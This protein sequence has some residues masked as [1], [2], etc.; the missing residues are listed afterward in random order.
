MA[1]GDNDSQK[2][3][4]V[5]LVNTKSGERLA[6]GYLITNLKTV[7]GNSNVLDLMDYVRVKIDPTDGNLKP[8]TEFADD[9]QWSDAAPNPAL[10]EL[11]DRLK[12][13]DGGGKLIIAGGDGTV[14]WGIQLIEAYIAKFDGKVKS[15][16]IAIIPMGTGNDLSRSL[17]MGPGFR[18]STTCCCGQ[19]DVEAL[20][21]SFDSAYEGILDLWDVT[22]SSGGNVF[23]KRMLINYISVGM[24][25]EIAHK[26]DTFRTNHPTLCKSRKLNKFWYAM[27]GFRSLCGQAT[28]NTIKKMKLSGSKQSAS[29]LGVPELKSLIVANIDSYASGMDFWKQGGRLGHTKFDDGELEICGYYGGFHMGCNQVGFRKSKRLAKASSVEF[30]IAGHTMVQIDGEPISIPGGGCTVEIK[31]HPK[32]ARVLTTV[33]KHATKDLTV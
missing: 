19:T 6:A 5:A 3:A 20:V 1:K 32:A 4:V 15:P 2:G 16:A 14:A 7:L 18:V 21:K 26:F 33:R 9:R 27:Y 17:G 8:K 12:K 23:E 13:V 25:A 10:H 28:L 24:D 31:K 29:K 30:K 22:M 11:F